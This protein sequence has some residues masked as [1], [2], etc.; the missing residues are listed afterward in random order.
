MSKGGRPKEYSGKGSS[1]F[2]TLFRNVLRSPFSS[3]NRS[4]EM[5]PSLSSASK[6]TQSQSAG[7]AHS[8]VSISDT[9]RL[10]AGE[11]STVPELADRNDGLSEALS[12]TST[13]PVDSVALAQAAAGLMERDSEMDNRLAALETLIFELKG[14]KVGNFCEL[15]K[16]LQ[17]IVEFAFRE[18][19][20]GG[21]AAEDKNYELCKRAR[22]LVLSLLVVFA[23][24]GIAISGSVQQ[25]QQQ[26]Q[27]QQT[28]ESVMRV[29]GSANGWDEIELAVQCASWA[30]GNA[31]NISGH[32]SEWFK[33][34]CA[35]VKLAAEQCYP[36]QTDRGPLEGPLPGPQAALTDSLLFLAHIVSTDYPVLDPD[37]VSEI[38]LSLCEMASKTRLVD[39]GDMEEVAW[40][41]TE[42]SH[43]HGVL[44]LLKTVIKYGAVTKGVLL[45]G[46]MLLCT[47]VNV[48][49]CKD[50]CCEIVYTLFTSCYMR[51]T[52]LLM[53]FILRKGDTGL[54]SKHIYGMS[55]LTP[56]QAAVNGMVYYITQVMETGFT[57]F[58][59]S[60]R[61]GNCLPVLGEAAQ[62]MHPEVLNLVFPY[63]CQVANDDRIDSMLPDDLAMLIAILENTVECRLT[64]KYEIDP[65]SDIDE[66]NEPPTLAYLYD[67]A[68]QAVVSIFRR[69]SDPPPI[70]LMNLLYK[71]RGVLSDELAQSMLLF[72]DA[73]GSLSSGSSNWLETLEEMMQLYYFDRSRSIPLRRQIAR[74]CARVFTDAFNSN[75]LTV[76]RLPFILSALEQLYLEEDEKLVGSILDIMCLLL[77]RTKDSAIFRDVLEYA[78]RAAIELDFVRRIQ[79]NYKKQQEA[80]SDSSMTKLQYLI[81]LMPTTSSPPLLGDESSHGRDE[82]SYSSWARVTQTSKTM[83]AAL[84]WR[85]SITD[86]ISDAIYA[87][88][89]S[90][91]ILLVNSLLDL[92][93]SDHAFPSVQR[94]IL[95]VFL[96]FHADVN[97]RLYILKSDRDTLIDHRVS[98]HENA[99]L[100]LEFQSVEERYTSSAEWVPFPIARYVDV[101]LYLL[102]TNTDVETF[103]V[104][105]RGLMIQLSNTYLF[106]V[107]TQQ[108]QRLVWYIV[109]Y[110]RAANFEYNTRARM[111]TDEK[112]YILTFTY[113]MLVSVMHYKELL[114]REGQEALI[115][116]LNDGL[117]VTSGASTKPQICLHVLSVAMLE[118]SG[119]MVRKLPGV[120]AQLVKIYSAARL[121]VHLLEFASSI[122]RDPRLYANFRTPEYRVLFAVAINYIRFHN[123]QRRREHSLSASMSG[124]NV[125]SSDAAETVDSR[126]LSTG[127]SLGADKPSVNDVALSQYVFIMA[128]QVIDVYFLSLSP[129]FK[130]EILDSLV[131]GLLQANYSSSS[132]DEVNEVCLDMILQNYSRSSEDIL[133]LSD[134]TIKEDLGPVVER[135]WIQHNG[136]VTIRAQ[137]DGPMAQI[138]IRSCS[139]TTSRIVD[140]PAEVCQKQAQRAEQLASSSPASPISESPNLAA[141]NTTSSMSRGRSIGRSR[142]LH[143]IANAVV[144]GPHVETEPMPLNSIA[145]LLRGELLSQAELARN[146]HFPIKYGPAPCLAMEFI[147]AYQGLQNLDVPVMLPPNLESIARS[148]R[149]FDNTAMVDTHK[150]SLAYVG[151]GQTTER[152]ILLNQ[153]GSPAYWNFLRGIGNIRR[154]GHMKGFSAGLDTSGNDT[155]GR[156]TIGW[157]DLIAK[158]VFHVGTLMPAQEENQEQIVRKK[159][160]MGND[161]VHIVFNESGRNYEFDTMSSQFNFVQIIVTP[162]DGQLSTGDATWLNDDQH[163][164]PG[165]QLYKVKTQINPNIPFIGPAAESKVLTLT[166][167]PAFV[168]SIAIHAAIFSQVYSSCKSADSSSAEYISLWRARLQIIKRVRTHAQ[169]ERAKRES[170]HGQPAETSADSD[171]FGE[172]ISDPSMAV[173]AA[174]ALGYLV[175][176][177]ESYSK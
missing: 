99:R 114:M 156:Y 162:V 112:N 110:A 140:L 101:L 48:P 88:P 78:L 16:M 76:M 95:S 70:S 166:A 172:E 150:V 103:V 157:R 134:V 130:A 125:R 121:S 74:I 122:S 80:G 117:S 129:N 87:P 158:L 176:D 55:M 35:W 96:R 81:Q 60:L 94:S 53:N 104:L 59:F 27:Y 10:Q 118:L 33:R 175:R 66:E 142:R 23:E 5:S 19:A 164:K 92:L 109:G 22:Q 18:S 141:G 132:M 154:L 65:G 30:S 148:L 42:P 131:T 40:I 120:L 133:K 90:D 61:T 54:N 138:I 58:Q 106:S 49:M 174:Q 7:T 36:E 57:G 52:L 144:T 44:Y 119:T 177:L 89:A 159:A 68:L 9:R 11:T 39:E 161:Y 12:T 25:Q 8:P 37:D 124:T 56:Y 29:I 169:R 64:D 111:S 128:Y 20:A 135:H 84:E 71:L 2:A 3:D 126:R 91:T 14:Q 115:N 85:M 168:R 163:K 28:I 41:W 21:K 34:A 139:G 32:I 47:T 69:K 24:G 93:Q 73:R 51:E 145:R 45:P 155:D 98:L 97:L 15:W 50:L 31:R 136:I 72:I 46:I 160:H 38:T 113:G 137:K 127:A 77:K 102:Q 171:E 108:I 116:A 86:T 79:P 105:C 75:S 147:N 123:N 1:S 6:T 100:R 83:L 152:E 153:Q 165:V 170:A 167:L 107:C 149:I 62:C 82:K 17:D 4:K 173:T 63:V 67:G 143:S 26:Q 13:A 43:L 146:P 151:P